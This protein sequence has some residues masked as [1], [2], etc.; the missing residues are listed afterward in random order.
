MALHLLERLL[1]FDPTDRPTA[2][3]ALA[4]PYFTGLANSELEPTTQPISRLEFEFERRKL[5]R[6][7]VRELIYREILEYHPQMLHEYLRGGDQA[8]FLYPRER[9]IGSSDEPEKPNADYCI[10]LH[11]GEV[12]GHT[13]VTDGLNKPLLNTR[14]FLKSES[15]GASKCIVVKEKREKDIFSDDQ[16]CHAKTDTIAYKDLPL[17]YSANC[18]VARNLCLTICMKHEEHLMRNRKGLLNSKVCDD[19][20]ETEARPIHGGFTSESRA[21]E[22]DR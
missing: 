11:V 1:A 7:D 17:F 14:N 18:H 12:P 21:H 15:I 13:S 9:V 5:A 22:S 6:E 8:N 16:I 19:T 20:G 2:A 3:E 4:D 10:K